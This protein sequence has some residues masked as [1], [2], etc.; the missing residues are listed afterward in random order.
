MLLGLLRFLWQWVRDFLP[1]SGPASLADALPSMDLT[2]ALL[3]LLTVIA[4]G[5]MIGSSLLSRKR[6]AYSYCGLFLV[7]L[8]LEIIVSPHFIFG[9]DKPEEIGVAETEVWVLAIC[10]FCVL[11]PVFAYCWWLRR[12]GALS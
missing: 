5:L 7:V 1:A 8:L 4:A 3:T 2:F 9:R 12:R 10:Y 6:R 11:V